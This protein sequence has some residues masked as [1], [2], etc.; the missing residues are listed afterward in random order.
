MER[1]DRRA[2]QMKNQ[3]RKRSEKEKLSV[4]IT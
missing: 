1:K 4:K 2:K 3:R